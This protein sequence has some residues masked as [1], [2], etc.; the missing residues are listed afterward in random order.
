M[1]SPFLISRIIFIISII[2]LFITLNLY[3]FIK[4]KQV[5]RNIEQNYVIFDLG[6]LF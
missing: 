3:D 6:M 2:C 4:Q 5:S 1:I